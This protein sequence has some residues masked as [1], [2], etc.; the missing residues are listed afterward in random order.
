M[1]YINNNMSVEPVTPTQ[2]QVQIDNNVIQLHN[3]L[4]DNIVYTI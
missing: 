2:I 4:F 1:V 3:Q